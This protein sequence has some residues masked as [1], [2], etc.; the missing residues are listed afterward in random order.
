M[1]GLVTASIAA[2]GGCNGHSE[3]SRDGASNHS[4]D[5]DSLMAPMKTTQ[6]PMVGQVDV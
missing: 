4:A 3:G 1:I 5:T 6:L 2:D